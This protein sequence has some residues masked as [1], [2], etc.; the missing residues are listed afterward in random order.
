MCGEKKNR[1][2]ECEVNQN[3]RERETDIER[4]RD[5][6]KERGSEGERERENSTC[7]P[8]FLKW[9]S[10]LHYAPYVYVNIN[11]INVAVCANLIEFNQL[12]LR[13]VDLLVFTK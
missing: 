3:E 11:C 2:Q 13:L 4:E 1:K 8:T 9:F 5:T 6:N 7:E 12:L 10:F